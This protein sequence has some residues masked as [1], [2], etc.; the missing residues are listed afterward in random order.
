MNRVL[1]NVLISIS[2]IGVLLFLKHFIQ[3]QILTW[4]IVM[5]VAGILVLL[6]ASRILDGEPSKIKTF[7]INVIGI[8]LLIGG[9]NFLMEHF[10]LKYWLIYGIIGIILYQTHHFISE[11]F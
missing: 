1:D 3:T 5:I 10:T 11:R 6:F 8:T 4:S 9:T 2:T 7:A